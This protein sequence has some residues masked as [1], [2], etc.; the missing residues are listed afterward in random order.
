M[1]TNV[2]TALAAL[3]TWGGIGGFLVLSAMIVADEAVC[4]YIGGNIGSFLWVTFHFVV[5]PIF[6]ALY[7][8]LS[9]AKAVAVRRLKEAITCVILCALAL[10]YIYLAVSGNIQ[11]VQ[12]FGISFQ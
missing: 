5:N 3:S 2:R 7:I 6:C 9:I 4:V 11:W 8:L 10:G 1:N 12:F